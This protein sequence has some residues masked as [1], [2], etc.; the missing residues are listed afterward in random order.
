MTLSTEE[1]AAKARLIDF[2]QKELRKQ[3]IQLTRDTI[4][5]VVDAYGLRVDQG[6]P[7]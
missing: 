1:L 3:A 5:A 7:F 6:P 4:E 2:I